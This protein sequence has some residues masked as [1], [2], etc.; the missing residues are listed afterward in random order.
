V[1][2]EGVVLEVVRAFNAANVPYMVVGSLSSNVYG[3]PRSTNDADFVVELSDNALANIT[4][5]LGAGYSLD[6]QMSFE[7]ITATTRYRLKHVASAFLVELFL[8]SNDA[9][10]RA[11]FVRRCR[12]QFA[13]QDVFVPTPEDVIITKLRWSRHGNRSKDVDDVRGILSVRGENLDWNYLDGWCDIHGTLGLLE[14][15]RMFM[16]NI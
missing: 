8:L 16:T 1:T 11:R 6:P 12:T 15:I 3:I 7:T 9:H 14:Q 2:A 13:G 10:D 4:Q 5:R